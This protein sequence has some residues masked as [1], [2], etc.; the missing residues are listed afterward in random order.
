ME[1]EEYSGLDDFTVKSCYENAENPEVSKKKVMFQ[2]DF[3]DSSQ[4]E[5][6]HF[7]LQSIIRCWKY[8]ICKTLFKTQMD[9]SEL[10][11]IEENFIQ[12]KQKIIELEQ[13]LSQI[14]H[15]STAVCIN[16]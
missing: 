1:E 13:L 7:T 6:V 12:I 3:K 16:S 14:Q 8:V 4:L 15:G 11:E 5:Q 2:F 9:P 10:L